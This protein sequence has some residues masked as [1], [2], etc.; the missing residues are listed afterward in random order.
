MDKRVKSTKGA[1]TKALVKLLEKKH[2]SRITIKELCEEADVNRATFYAHYTDRFDQLSQVEGEFIE[3][4]NCYLE[5]YREKTE[6]GDTVAAVSRVFEYVDD[7]RELCRALLSENGNKSFRERLMNVIGG[8][9]MKKWQPKISVR[10]KLEKYMMK[11]LAIGCIGTVMSWLESE[12][13]LS[14]RELAELIVSMVW[15]GM[16]RFEAKEGTL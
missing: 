15:G 11:F 5:Q 10:R 6:Q 12:N 8:C 9:I 4:I 2:I 16:T 7:N 14:P 1:L 3:G 13:S